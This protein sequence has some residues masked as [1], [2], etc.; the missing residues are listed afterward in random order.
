MTTPAMLALEEFTGPFLYRYKAPGN[1][2]HIR[3]IILDHQLYF[4][5]PGQFQDP[6]DSRPSVV[7]EDLE[8]MYRFLRKV[9][10][11]NNANAPVEQMSQVLSQYDAFMRK[12]PPDKLVALMSAPFLDEEM[13]QHRICSMST[14]PDNAHLWKHFAGDSS[15]CCFEFHNATDLLV[16]R[17]F[18]ARK[19]DYRDHYTLDLSDY[20][21][22]TAAF[23]FY[24]TPPYTAEEEVRILLL[25]RERPHVQRFD[26]GR[27]TR[28]IVGHRMTA[29]N[30]RVIQKWCRSRNPPLEI[31]EQQLAE[32]AESGVGSTHPESASR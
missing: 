25:P 23:L 8:P 5:A 26:P 17:E 18:I 10:R 21:N 15:G 6:L 14:R 4:S 12:L 2:G 19:V 31:A 9:Y 28:I 3:Q 16:Q 24:K 20:K 27:L 13:Q 22:V 32:D 30:R 1:I 7:I 11:K 29:G